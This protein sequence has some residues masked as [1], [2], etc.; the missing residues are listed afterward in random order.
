[1]SVHLCCRG[2]YLSLFWG[3]LFVTL[4]TLLLMAL[5][6]VVILTTKCT[7]TSNHV[8]LHHYDT[9]PSYLMQL[10]C[11][12]LCGAFTACGK[13]CS[14][15][16]YCNVNSLLT[17]NSVKHTLQ[18][19]SPHYMMHILRV[20]SSAHFFFIVTWTLYWPWSVASSTT[21]FSIVLWT[22][23]GPWTLWSIH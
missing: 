21:S 8:K 9:P 11:C 22:F 17:M 23:F 14:L 10:C 18:N 2:D 3:Q 16:F 12:T 1:M 6:R 20:A 15:F 7:S 5:C 13:L 19:T 4:P